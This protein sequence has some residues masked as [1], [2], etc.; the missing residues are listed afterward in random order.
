MPG[1]SALESEC[2]VPALIIANHAP[3]AIAPGSHCLRRSAHGSRWF[4]SNVVGCDTG[5]TTS[6]EATRG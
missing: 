3:P 6:V 1:T 4:N 5:A 2:F